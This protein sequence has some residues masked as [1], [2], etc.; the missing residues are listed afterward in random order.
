V[1]L[2]LAGDGHRLAAGRHGRLLSE[3]RA[4][5]W[6]R[7]RARQLAGL[8]PARLKTRLAGLE[9]KLDT[10]HDQERTLG[11][12]LADPSGHYDPQALASVADRLRDTLATGETRADQSAL[13]A[14][15]QGA[16]RQR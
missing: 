13:A 10:L 6:C 3:V 7:A 15:D 5:W 12:Q 11:A 1:V 16:P 14:A 8:E 9:A 4:T 2:R